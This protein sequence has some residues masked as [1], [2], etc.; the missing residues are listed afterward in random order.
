MRSLVVVALYTTWRWLRDSR[1]LWWLIVLAVLVPAAVVASVEHQAGP[2]P[3]LAWG[4][5]LSLFPSGGLALMFA[6]FHRSAREHRSGRD[7]LLAIWQPSPA[8]QYLAEL[9]VLSLVSALAAAL[10]TLA[11][12]MLSMGTTA[13]TQGFGAAA[14]L[15]LMLSL[16]YALMWSVG[17]AIGTRWSGP[18]GATL[19]IAGPVLL[20][21]MTVGVFFL[22]RLPASMWEVLSSLVAM[23]PWTLLSGWGSDVWGF[24]GAGGLFFAVTLLMVT[25]ILVINLA[26]LGRRLYL[27]GPHWGRWAL[28][29]LAPTAALALVV[30]V[31]AAPQSLSPTPPILAAPAPPIAREWIWVRFS[32][33]GVLTAVARIQPVDGLWRLWLNPELTVTAVEAGGHPLRF[34]RQEGFIQVQKGT[35]RTART[36]TVRYQGQVDEWSANYTGGMGWVAAAFSSGQGAYLPAGTWYPVV[37]PTPS[38]VLSPPVARYSVTVTSPYFRVLTNVGLWRSAGAGARRTTGVTLVAG[39]FLRTETD[40]LTEWAGPAE[41]AFLRGQGILGARLSTHP[42]GASP[43]GY[44]IWHRIT[45]ILAP[46][47][48][49]VDDQFGAVASGLVAL[50]NPNPERAGSLVTALAEATPLGG[51]LP[52]SF[53]PVPPYASEPNLLALLWSHI[54]PHWTRIGTSIGGTWPADQV[55]AD[56][57]LV[58]LAN[59]WNAGGVNIVVGPSA[60]DRHVFRGLSAAEAAQFWRRFASRAAHGWPTAAEVRRWRAALGKEPVRG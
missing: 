7:R 9:F 20:A 60:T 40:G 15:W 6:G 37:P 34:T 43:S 57:V 58:S 2:V 51:F 8:T 31:A 3:W 47:L 53:F 17:T 11:V 54:S 4:P 30:A 50:D 5:G 21:V 23:S 14:T 18:G 46:A 24:G 29:C 52:Y 19:A 49:E 27:S 12:V 33:A 59:R 22:H 39:H 36:V 48:N 55:P 10:V 32:T 42:Y 45:G 28:E 25:A 1:M 16:N 56:R 13:A 35:W 41:A 26:A 38:E 44:A